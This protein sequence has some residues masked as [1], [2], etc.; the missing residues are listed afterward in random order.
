MPYCREIMHLCV[1]LYS[2]VPLFMFSLNLRTCVYV[3]IHSL[4]ASML[5]MYC[6]KAMVAHAFIGCLPLVRRPRNR[7]LTYFEDFLD[8][9]SDIRIRDW[10]FAVEKWEDT[11]SLIRLQMRDMPRL[12]ARRL[13]MI[14]WWTDVKDNIS[15]SVAWRMGTLGIF[16]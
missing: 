2:D 5:V 8:S 14:N 12:E 10:I 9:Q 11:P 13:Q 3:G 4:N 16:G 15:N 1:F 7:N 6:S